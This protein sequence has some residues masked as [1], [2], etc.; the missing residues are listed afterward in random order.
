MQLR[1]SQPNQICSVLPSKGTKA[2]KVSLSQGSWGRA[3]ANAVW[4]AL[5]LFSADS[6]QSWT[7]D[8]RSGSYKGLKAASR[9]AIHIHTYIYTHINIHKFT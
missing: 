1:Q 6:L 2:Q 3:H 5:K 7:A 8:L 4:T 9:V